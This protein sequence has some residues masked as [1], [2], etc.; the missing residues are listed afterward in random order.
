MKVIFDRC[1]CLQ[2]LQ[3]KTH[4]TIEQ[5]IFHRPVRISARTHKH[6]LSEKR[7]SL[8]E[9]NQLQNICVLFCFVGIEHPATASVVVHFFSMLLCF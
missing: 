8:L 1:V 3:K 5:I 6:L 9:K 4:C 7:P 2:R